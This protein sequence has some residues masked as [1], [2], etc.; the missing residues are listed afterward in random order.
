VNYIYPENYTD[1]V[2]DVAIT[3]PIMDLFETL[4]ETY[5]FADEKYGHAQ[6]GAGG[7]ME[8]T[9]VSFMGGFDRNLIA[10]ELAHQW[11]GDKI[12]CGSWQDIWLN[13]GFATYLSGLVFE[14]LDGPGQFVGWK[15]SQVNYITSATGGSVYVPLA[16]ANN[17]NRIFDSRLSY[18]KGAMVVEMLRWKLGDANFFQGIRNYL[19]DPGLA[20]D[21]AVTPD[22][23]LHLET[24]SG[25][26][27]DEFFN[28]WVYKQGY[29]T[30]NIT[31]QNLAPGTV[32]IVVQQS[33][34][35]LSVPF[36]EMPIPVRVFGAVGQQMDL[37]LDN[38]TDN[39]IFDVA[40]PFSVTNVS[41]DPEKHIISKNN[42]TSLGTAD[43]AIAD[44]VK[45]YP[46]PTSNILN[47][48]VPSF[49]SFESATVYNSVGQKVIVTSIQ[50]I[51]VS[52]LS[53][54]V[55][56]INIET[57]AATVHRKFIKN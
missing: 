28:D 36:F 1:A 43:M 44:A 34:S 40:V 31:A 29:P 21:Y 19:A 5:P 16:D 52:M 47:I 11:F 35:H 3:L 14:N 6:F 39:Q 25:L 30:Y 41:F 27:L 56:F 42:T 10:H 7:G 57:S 51:D 18:S 37:V 50:N 49:A 8:H 13:E 23:Q 46:N 17:S 48:E 22:L 45:L 54:G 26:D 4:F 12:T 32:R 53:N 15:N 33:Q 55:Y 2:A 38:N 24:A 9:T 20:Y